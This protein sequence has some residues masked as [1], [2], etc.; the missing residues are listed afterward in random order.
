MASSSSY[1]LKPNNK[2]KSPMNASS[3]ETLIPQ[4]NTIYVDADPSNF[5]A[6]VQKLTGASTDPTVQNLPITISPRPSNAK[7]Y[8]VDV[9]PVRPSFNLQEQRQRTPNLIHL[10]INQNDRLTIGESFFAP[11]KRIMD[12]SPVSILDTFLASGS[13][14]RAP[15]SPSVQEERAIANKSF[16]LHP[17]PFPSSGKAEPE[18]LPLFPTSPDS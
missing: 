14:P 18:L 5:R 1:S 3:F 13:T 10:Q 16:Y 7:H 12:T 4:Q 9:V 8:Y 15:V 11:R 17:R 6:V 2:S